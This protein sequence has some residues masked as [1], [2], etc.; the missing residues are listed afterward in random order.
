M[1]VWCGIATCAI[2]IGIGGIAL[3]GGVIWGAPTFAVVGHTMEWYN[4]G[5]GWA[6]GCE[7]CEAIMRSFRHHTLKKSLVVVL[8]AVLVLRFVRVKMGVDGLSNSIGVCQILCVC[9]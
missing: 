1:S 5:W 2:S 7:R 6:C 4:L 8:R 3:S 9:V